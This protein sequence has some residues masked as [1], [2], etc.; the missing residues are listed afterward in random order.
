MAGDEF[1]NVVSYRAQNITEQNLLLLQIG[2]QVIP[3]SE[4]TSDMVMSMTD[5]EKER[6]KQVY[7]LA[8][9]QAEFY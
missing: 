5:E 1:I 3:V 4:V 8:M 9:S 2:N 6:Y 7:Q